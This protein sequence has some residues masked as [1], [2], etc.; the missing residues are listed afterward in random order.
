MHNYDTVTVATSELQNITP[1]IEYNCRAKM[2]R[3]AEGFLENSYHRT[4]QL[5]RKPTA[6][7]WLWVF[8][9][10]ATRSKMSHKVL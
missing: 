10:K 1:T 4:L 8:A 2:N 6:T 3:S 5:N 7:R 9:L